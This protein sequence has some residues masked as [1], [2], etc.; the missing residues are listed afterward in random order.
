MNDGNEENRGKKDRARIGWYLF[1]L[2]FV[3]FTLFCAAYLES[4]AYAATLPEIFMGTFSKEYAGASKGIAQQPETGDVITTPRTV[5]ILGSK[6]K[7]KPGFQLKSAASTDS[8]TV[9]VTKKKWK[10][11]IKAKK[12]GTATITLTSVDG[13]TRDYEVIVEDPQVKNLKVVDFVRLKEK[14]YITGVKYLKPTSVGSNKRKIAQIY[15]SSTG[16]NIINVFGSGRTKITVRYGE[17]KRTGRIRAKLP[18]MASKDVKLS[19]KPKKIRIK[20]IPSG[21]TPVY[22]STDSKVAVCNKDGHVAPKG[23]GKCT[24]YTRVGNTYLICH[25]TVEGF[26]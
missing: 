23:N 16:E 11:V 8:K 10:A 12:A 13:E 9:S 18:Y 26:K 1:A 24:I 3:F 6:W 5:V 19:T 17:Y 7:L 21:W 14:E 22:S 20:N 2:I 25:V 15:R 4:R